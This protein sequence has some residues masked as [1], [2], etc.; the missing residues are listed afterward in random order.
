V[1]KESNYKALKEDDFKE[2]MI[3][4]Y[5]NEAKKLARYEMAETDRYIRFYIDESQ[6]LDQA[7]SF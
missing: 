1:T 2:K 3:R 5:I 6:R 7:A 4:E